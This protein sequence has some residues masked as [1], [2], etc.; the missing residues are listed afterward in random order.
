M[1]NGHY[2]PG[3]ER[4]ESPPYAG[5]PIWR[6]I[7]VTTDTT[8]LEYVKRVVSDFDRAVDKDAG[9]KQKAGSCLM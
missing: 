6:T 4:F 2:V 1:E 7:M 5:K 8:A 9:A 3:L